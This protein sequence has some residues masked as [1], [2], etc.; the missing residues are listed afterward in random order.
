MNKGAIFDSTGLYRYLLWREWDC[1]LPIVTFVMLN[2]SRAD[3][4]VDDPT[5]RRC[6]GFARSW[7]YGSLK[8]VNL[9]AY[10]ASR[11]NLLFQSQAPIGQDNDRYLQIISQRTSTLVLAWGNSGNYQQRDR[12][13][14]QLLK[15][16]PHCYCLGLTQNKNPRHPLYLKRQSTLIRFSL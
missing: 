16:H 2:P 4:E 8:V 1:L 11:P 9:F 7:G 3:A 15:D 14:L 12:A 13:V 6:L 5:I 10:R